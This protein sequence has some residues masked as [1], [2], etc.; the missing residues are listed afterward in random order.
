MRSEE[1]SEEQEPSNRRGTRASHD[2]RDEGRYEH[3][4][5][6]LYYNY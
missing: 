4:E 2:M 6:V 5:Q 1:R 3:E